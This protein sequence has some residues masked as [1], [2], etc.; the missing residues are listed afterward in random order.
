MDYRAL[1]TE[2]SMDTG[3]RIDTGEGNRNP[4]RYLQASGI[5][6]RSIQNPKSK[7]QNRMTRRSRWLSAL[8]L[9][10]ALAGCGN[11]PAA[12]PPAETIPETTETE[13]EVET[14]PEEE[15]VTETE[16]VPVEDTETEPE[17]ETVTETRPLSEDA[18][19]KTYQGP[20]DL[21]TIVFP[22]NY[23]YT[24]TDNTVT[25]TSGDEGF[26][27]FIEVEPAA[28]GQELTTPQL[29]EALK[30]EFENRYQDIEWQGSELQPDE[31]L[32]LDW[33][34]SDNGKELDAITFIEQRGDNVFVLTLMGV[35]T[36]YSEYETDARDLIGS[37]NIQQ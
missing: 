22:D 10:L 18:Q 28:A 4:I 30:A 19:D 21:Y 23:T 32:R 3:P 12:D 35:D 24:E 7:I 34:G 16:P 9:A 5:S 20:N 13:P 37:Y 26:V 27:G 6:P 17:E 36:P 14:E 8:I 25:F 11:E 2:N 15:T 29:E 33:T 31:S 1:L